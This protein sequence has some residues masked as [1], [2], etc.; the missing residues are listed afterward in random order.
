MSKW[1]GKDV[2]VFL[3]DGYDLLAAKP[4]ELSDK[5]IVGLEDT[6][7]LGDAWDEFTPTGHAAA[8]L[9]Q[10][11]A[12]Y[13]DS[14]DNI[15]DIWSG[16]GGVK[17][18]LVYGFEGNTIGVRAVG[19][20]GVFGVGYERQGRRRLLTRANVD[21]VLSGPKEDLVI[22]HAH[23]AETDASG[24]TESSSV[25][26]ASGPM[27]RSTDV[28]SS[29]VANPSIIVTATPH[30]FANGQI[31]LIA[32]HSGSTPDINDEHVATVISPT[33]FS[34]PV[35]VTVG[36][37]GGTVVQSNT[38]AGGAGYLEVSALALG[39]Y[40]SVT[41]TLRDSPDDI[42]FGDLGTFTIVTA[43]RVAE[44]IEIAGTIERFTA[45]SYAFNG[46]GSAQSIN[47]LVGLHR[48]Q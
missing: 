32:G 4:T 44:R 43:A 41:I 8:E 38:V 31:V 35:N 2:K 34:I 30:G 25:D 33:T 48:I 47:Y 6:D 23:G 12:F 1:G 3:A 46:S 5:T 27:N 10:A 20:A 17:R 16:Q 24:D 11:G 40:D 39:G 13:D 15:H 28:T 26:H 42:T 45:E 36:G 18:V 29:S 9:S 7:G 14:T 21:Y 19:H 37:T 22:L